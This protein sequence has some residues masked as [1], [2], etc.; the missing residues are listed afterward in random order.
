M[1]SSLREVP[2]SFCS[3]LWTVFL[4]LTLSSDVEVNPGPRFPCS[5]CYKSVCNNQQAL[6]CDTCVYWCHRVCCG[7]DAR[8]YTLFHNL[9]EF[10]WENL[11]DSG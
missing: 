7:V 6:Q 10:N 1:A 4:L 5:V 11:I 8:T 9:E 2:G 3:V